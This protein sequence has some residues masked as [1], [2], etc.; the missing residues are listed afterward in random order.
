VWLTERRFADAAILDVHGALTGTAANELLQMTT[1]TQVEAGVRLVVLNLADVGAI[2]DDGV[3]A[4]H[5]VAESTRQRG[6]DVRIAGEL[7]GITRV[8]AVRP[9]VMAFQT[10]P[11]VDDALSDVR[12]ALEQRH[13]RVTASRLTSWLNRLKDRLFTGN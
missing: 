13:A 6:V 2:D 4:V 5:A 7:A 8:G 1:R 3:E 10:F 11:T 12:A 9:I